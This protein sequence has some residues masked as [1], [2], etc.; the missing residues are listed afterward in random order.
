M[1]TIRFMYDNYIDRA[2]ALTASTQ[3]TNYPVTNL[4]HIWTERH[5]RTTGIASEWILVNLATADGAAGVKAFVIK[6][7]NYS[8]GAT[9]KIQGNA[10]NN[11]SSPT[12]NVT[13]PVTSTFIAYNI[14][15]YYWDTAQIYPWWRW[16][17]EDTGS[18]TYLKTGRPYLG[19]WWA[20]S[21]NFANNYTRGLTDTSSKS[22]SLGGQLSA[23]KRSIIKELVYQFEYLIPADVD[24]FESIFQNYVQ[25]VTP[26]FVSQDA[27][28]L[29]AKT[30]YVENQQSWQFQHIYND[31][32][33]NLNISLKEAQ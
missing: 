23:V 9:L 5:H 13:I 33:Y 20:P 32:L 4:Q 15:E 18:H 25:L 26:Y 11:W 7:H 14:I 27:D 8:I 17:I 6:N 30:Y 28:A 3:A 19:L 1:K 24:T 22:Y 2:V 10:I 29:G 16:T 31:L 12:I 21:K